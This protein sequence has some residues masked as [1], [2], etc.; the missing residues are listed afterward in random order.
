MPLPTGRAPLTVGT[1]G[2]GGCVVDVAAARQPCWARRTRAGVAGAAAV[3]EGV[4][5]GAGGRSSAAVAT[6]SRRGPRSWVPIVIAASTPSSARS[7]QTPISPATTARCTVPASRSCRRV[8]PIAPQRCC[9]PDIRRRAS[10]RA[11]DEESR[12]SYPHYGIVKRLL[13]HRSIFV[14]LLRGRCAGG[15]QGAL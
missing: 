15:A 9:V 12:R 14:G 4:L 10:R 5:A 13:R 8:L 6:A 1:A 11:F 2:P 3:V 7:A